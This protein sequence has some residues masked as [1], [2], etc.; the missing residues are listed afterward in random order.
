MF[1]NIWNKYKRLN[2][3]HP[4]TT[5]MITTGGIYFCGEVVGQKVQNYLNESIKKSFDYKN[6]V[7][8]P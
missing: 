2:D 1:K 4:L 7:R 8:Y 6:L 5:K 3:L